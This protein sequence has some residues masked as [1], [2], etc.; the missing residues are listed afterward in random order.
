MAS[1]LRTS[2]AARRAIAAAYTVIALLAASRAHAGL[3]LLQP[4]RTLHGDAPLIVTVLADNDG[5]TSKTYALPADLD[6]S[7][8]NA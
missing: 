3:T 5:S 2:R 4:P 1:D 7:V 8:S 6:A